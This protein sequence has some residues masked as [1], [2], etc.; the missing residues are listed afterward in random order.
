[1]PIKPPQGLNLIETS[2]IKLLELTKNEKKLEKISA[3]R[4]V[5]I[6]MF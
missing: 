2:Q 3:L 5:I 1:M 6:K 4:T